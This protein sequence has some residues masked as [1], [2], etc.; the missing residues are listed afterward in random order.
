MTS[1]N[2]KNNIF[3]LIKLFYNLNLIKSENTKRNY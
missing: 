3:R 2:D 1:I